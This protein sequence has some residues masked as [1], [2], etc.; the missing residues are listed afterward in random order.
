MGFIDDPRPGAHVEAA[1]LYILDSMAQ[2]ISCVQSDLQRGRSHV[3]LAEAF[4]RDQA[5]NAAAYSLLQALTCKTRSR[6]IATIL[7][8]LVSEL[9]RAEFPRKEIVYFHIQHILQPLALDV[10]WPLSTAKLEGIVHQFV[11]SSQE[12]A[13]ADFWQTVMRIEFC[14]VDGFTDNA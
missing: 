13:A 4:I 3:L 12:I 14:E 10:G 5:Y 1:C 9:T 7:N 6:D 8:L 11:F 2:N